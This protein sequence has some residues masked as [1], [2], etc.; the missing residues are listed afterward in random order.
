MR[1]ST[2]QFYANSLDGILNQQEQLNRLSQQMATGR[3][4]VNPADDPSGSARVVALSQSIAVADK[5]AG[6]AAS[7]VDT[8][9]QES[10]TL[11]NVSDLLRQ[12]R[13]LALQMGNGT[14]NDDTRR[15]AAA[16]V[17]NQLS[18]LLQLANARD[19][20]G[21]YLFAGSKS[22]IQPFA[23]TGGTPAVSY[24]GDSGQR[25]VQIHGSRSIPVSDS[26]QALFMGIRDGN[27][28]FS[29]V[30]ASG[31]TGTGLIGMGSVLDPA[32]AIGRLTSGLTSY[33]ITFASGIPDT[34]FMVT[35]GSGAT[36]GVVASGTYTP[37]MSV[38]IQEAGIAVELQGEPANGDSFTISPAKNQDVFTTLAQLRDILSQPTSD[39][40][41]KARF[42]QQLNQVIGNLDQAQTNVLSAQSAIGVRLTEARAAQ[43]ANNTLKVQYQTTLSGVQDVNY[44][45]VITQFNQ[46]KV[47]LEAAQKTFV[48]IQGLTLFNYIK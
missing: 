27:G 39:P 7:A 31:N 47:A 22:N 48:Q 34:T 15:N 25:E 46:S 16:A 23:L 21:N 38:E 26:G 19:G 20:N 9:T 32:K 13:N 1:I 37:G 17:T 41:Q 44:A 14:Q 12:V 6:N 42:T 28:T 36:S 11:Q 33:T 35:S 5:Y 18:Q 40:A 8:L 2:S 3:R 10:T 4:I 45:E 29:S 43:S 30:A 24:S